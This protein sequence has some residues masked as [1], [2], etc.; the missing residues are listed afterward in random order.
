[1]R[2]RIVIGVALLASAI[3]ALCPPYVV[4]YATGSGEDGRHVVTVIRYVEAW[5]DPT[6][7]G[8]G[9]SATLDYSLLG[10]QLGLVWAAAGAVILVFSRKKT[11]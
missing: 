4:A 7:R 9:E 6:V 11:L 8:F 5:N 3:M 10:M 1:M 2:T